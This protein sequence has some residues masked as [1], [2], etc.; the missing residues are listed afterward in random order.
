MH[1]LFDALMV[2]VLMPGLALFV[3]GFGRIAE[4]L[5]RLN[6]RLHR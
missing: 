4:I 5:I 3:F 1:I 2:I 6:W